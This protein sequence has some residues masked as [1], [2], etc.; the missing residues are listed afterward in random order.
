MNVASE[1]R[2][3]FSNT[4]ADETLGDMKMRMDWGKPVTRQVEY[5]HLIELWDILDNSLKS[6]N[7]LIN[8]SIDTIT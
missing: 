5:F 2:K 8:E 3:T 7:E 4:T 1:C 6:L